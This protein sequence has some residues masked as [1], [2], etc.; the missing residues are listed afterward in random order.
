MRIRSRVTLCV[1]ERVAPVCGQVA[2]RECGQEAPYA[3]EQRVY[4]NGLK[5]AQTMDFL[6]LCTLMVS[7]SFNSVHKLGYFAS[8]SGFWRSV[9]TIARRGYAAG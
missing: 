2:P 3:R 4:T 6:N 5:H 8:S 9:Y 7:R 1:H